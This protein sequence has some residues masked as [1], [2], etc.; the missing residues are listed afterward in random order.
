MSRYRGQGHDEGLE[1]FKGIEQPEPHPLPPMVPLTQDHVVQTAGT[2][3]AKFFGLLSVYQKNDGLFA[4][5]TECG[6]LELELL[7]HEDNW[8]SFCLNGQPA[9]GFENLR[10]IVKNGAQEGFVGLQIR[11]AN[12]S[13][14]T[15]PIGREYQVPDEL[16]PEWTE[17]VGQYSIINPDPYMLI[18]G[19]ASIQIL[20]SG[21]MYHTIPNFSSNV[22]DPIYEDEAIKTGL[23]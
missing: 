9:P 13:I 22:L 19:S 10:V 2:Y 6:S 17:R 14:Y 3:A 16:R 8:F 18:D 11:D 7:P 4:N 21:V 15:Q 5:C 23:G 1:I 20:P 12:G